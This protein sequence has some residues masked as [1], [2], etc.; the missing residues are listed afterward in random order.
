MNIKGT[1]GETAKK[2]NYKKQTEIL[3][4]KSAIYENKFIREAKEHF[5]HQKKKNQ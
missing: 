1:V 3:E 4:Q 2:E 5:R